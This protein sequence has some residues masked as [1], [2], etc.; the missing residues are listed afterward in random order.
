MSEMEDE[1][2]KRHRK[3][4]RVKPHHAKREVSMMPPSNPSGAEESDSESTLERE[5]NEI[6]EKQRAL[7]ARSEEAKGATDQSRSGRKKGS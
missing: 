2:D 1:G 6:E 4:A 3:K 7:S 5:Q